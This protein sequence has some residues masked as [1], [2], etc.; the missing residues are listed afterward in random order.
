KKFNAW[1]E[2]LA[3]LP[4]KQTRVL[5]WPLV[6]VFGF[7]AKPDEHIFLKPKVTRNAAGEYGFPF[8]YESRPNWNTYE[9]LLGF[10]AAVTEDNDD[11]RP[12]DMIDAQSFIWV[13]GSDE[14]EE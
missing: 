4:R 6:T 3:K 14:Y 5:T 7:M 9:S 13:Q 1:C 11:L 2:T 10:A 8:T 12:R